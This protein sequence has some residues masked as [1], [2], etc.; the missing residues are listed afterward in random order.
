MGDLVAGPESWTEHARQKAG[1]EVVHLFAGPIEGLEKSDNL[2]LWDDG[3]RAPTARH[4]WGDPGIATLRH[5]VDAIGDLL[6]AN[7][8]ERAR[9]VRGA[10]KRARDAHDGNPHVCS[11]LLKAV[12]GQAEGLAQQLR[13]LAAQLKAYG[14]ER[15]AITALDLADILET[16]SAEVLV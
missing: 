12:S 10:A 8:E 15:Q 4:I 3:R 7:D 16:V 9:R 2:K 1:G 13:A 5:G 6:R 11:D 14:K